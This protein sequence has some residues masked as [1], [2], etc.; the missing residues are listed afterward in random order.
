MI[1][2]DRNVCLWCGGCVPMCP[3][4]SIFLNE[5]RIEINKSCNDCLICI[6]VCPV[7]ALEVVNV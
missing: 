7:G 4:N 1:R 6:R 3:K 2:C 5:N